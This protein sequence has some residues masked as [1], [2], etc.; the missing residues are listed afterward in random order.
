MKKAMQMMVMIM[1]V[2]VGLI[3]DSHAHADV[4][5]ATPYV[6]NISTS[7]N[8]FYPR[9][10]GD[11]TVKFSGKGNHQ[12]HP[13]DELVFDIPKALK[14]FK[15][16]MWLEDYAQVRVDA[17]R[18]HVKFTGKVNGRINVKGQLK[19]GVKGSEELQTGSRQVVP[20]HLGTQIKNYPSV[21]VK[22]YAEENTGRVQEV[23]DFAYKG[24]NVHGNDVRLMDWYIVVNPNRIALADDVIVRDTLGFGHEL[25]PGSVKLGSETINATHG[26]LTMDKHSFQ[27]VLNKSYASGQG[28]GIYYQTRLTPGGE[29]SKTI[30]NSFTADY[31]I[32]NQTKNSIKGSGQIKNVFMTGMIDGED[33]P[34]K[35]DIIEEN[36]IDEQDTLGTVEELVTEN[37]V[38]VIDEVEAITITE[39]MPVEDYVDITQPDIHENGLEEI[40]TKDVPVEMET[41]IPN[42]IIETVS[43]SEHHVMEDLTNGDNKTLTE[44]VAVP[45]KH[46]N[47]KQ[48]TS[49]VELRAIAVN[50]ALPNTGSRTNYALIMVG[51]LLMFGLWI[52]RNIV[53]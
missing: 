26:S 23:S 36:N 17:G 24:G 7:T 35:A 39:N 30:S 40:N 4:L 15:Q 20:L 14:S 10:T 18:V 29:K 5:D 34:L 12:F 51:L 6:D 49:E 52:G 47:G 43:G 41:I 27:L 13:G 21:T 37:A 45:V 1:M 32:A 22:G 19:F 48:I 3:L 16:K 50:Q 42:K 53:K 44:G 31:Q 11:I 38:E 46:V 9:E 8:E 28:I 33:Q 25:V 2:S